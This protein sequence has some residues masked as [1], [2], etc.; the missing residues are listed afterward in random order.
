MKKYEV[1]IQLYCGTLDRV[2]QAKT[3]V[4]DGVTY[5]LEQV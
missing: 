3:V 5:R 2:R 1:T 4:I